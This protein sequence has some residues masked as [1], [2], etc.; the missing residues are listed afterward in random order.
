M[1]ARILSTIAVL[2][3]AACTAPEGDDPGDLPPDDP[4]GKDDSWGACAGWSWGDCSDLCPRPFVGY[5]GCKPITPFDALVLYELSSLWGSQPTSVCAYDPAHPAFGG[6]GALAPGN[7]FYCRNDDSVGWDSHFLAGLVAQHGDFA[8]VAVLAHEWGHLNQSRTGLLGNPW[9]TQK[10]NELHADCQAG[11]FSAVQEARGH[12]DVG[13][14]NEAFATFCAAGD[15]DHLWWNPQGHG[16]CAERTT[17]FG[18][19]YAQGRAWASSLCGPYSIATMLQ[20][21][22]Y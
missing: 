16:T 13:D 18:W 1:C 3:W 7:A 5:Q 14:V 22:P 9:R 8:S 17:A 11:L 2:L 12:L 19:G 15:P 6:C 10:Q 20:L 21:C 4:A